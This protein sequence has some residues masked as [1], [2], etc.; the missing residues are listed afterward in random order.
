MRRALLLLLLAAPLVHAGA[1][2]AA[3][4]QE[5][6]GLASTTNGIVLGPDGNFWVSEFVAGSVVR[7]SPAG[8]VLGRFPVGGGPT[9]LANGPGGRVWVAVTG[10]KKLVW[11]DATAAAPAAHDVPIL[12]PCKPIGLAPG[13]DGRLY[14]SMPDDGVS[15][16]GS[17]YVGRIDDDGTG[18]LDTATGRGR[19]FDIEVTG[20]KLYVPDIAGDVIRRLA[21]NSTF[22]PEATVSTSPGSGPD[23]IVSDGAGRLWVTLA[24]AGKVARFGAA[25]N[26][27][28]ALELA[29]LGGGFLFPFGIARGADG[30]IYATARDT[31][32]IGRI[33]PLT[34]QFVTF[35]AGGGSPWQMTAAADGAL[36]YTDTAN[37]RVLR[38][39]NAR[40]IVSAGEAHAVAP[41]AGSAGARVDSRGNVTQVVFDYGTTLA[42]GATTAPVGVPAGAGGA[43]DVR[44]DLTGLAPGTSYHVRV[45]ASNAE[46][47]ATGAD[48]TFT[49][50]A[51]PPRQLSARVTYGWRFSP[52]WTQLTRVVVRGLRGGETVRLTCRGKGCGTRSK[53]RHPRGPRLKL[54]RYF[55]REHKLRAR[56][57]V[58][59]RVTAPD[60][61]GVLSTLRTRRGKEPAVSR[62]CLAPGTGARTRCR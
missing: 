21:L 46:G 55:G 50:P 29:P 14:F 53:T 32:R 25:D 41:T 36:W 7:L 1:A 47:G 4:V 60:A 45:R 3:V 49:T 57:R 30:R 42:Y 28:N 6:G 48:T 40:P 34:S 58:R 35:P 13:G 5:F 39:V 11:I 38:F 33:D 9:T 24:G 10:A 37:N 62:R 8:A 51:A 18:P 56:T 61:V 15:C 59:I 2:R 44:S 54:T 22:T 52:T 12:L 43:V 20:G 23:G 31:A 16:G 17:D 27:V 19:A 26:G